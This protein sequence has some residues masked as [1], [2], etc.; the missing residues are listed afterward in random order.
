MNHIESYH[1][2][3][4]FDKNQQRLNDFNGKK[5][6][7]N[8]CGSEF[9]NVFKEYI[10]IRKST[11][12]RQIAEADRQIAAADQRSAEAREGAKKAFSEFLD[13]VI[14]CYKLSP[15]NKKLETFN[16]EVEGAISLAKSFEFDYKAI[17]YEKFGNEIELENGFLKFFKIE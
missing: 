1:N 14:D 4:V 3:S 2:N 13:V 9:K 7:I 17:I 15:N 16:S 10:N 6:R 11:A 12:D 5:D 8:N